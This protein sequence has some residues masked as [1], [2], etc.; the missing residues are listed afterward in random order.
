MICNYIESDISNANRIDEVCPKLKSNKLRA[1]LTKIFE[2]TQ[3]I[4]YTITKTHRG[5]E[6][7][8]TFA[9]REV[10]FQNDTDSQ[11]ESVQDVVTNWHSVG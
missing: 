7:D 4:V 11:Q 5:W 1:I 6:S 9:A 10:K 2:Y 3:N 8:I